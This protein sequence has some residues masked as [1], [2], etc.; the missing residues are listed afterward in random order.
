VGLVHG[1]LGGDNVFRYGGDNVFRC[2]N[3]YKV[4][5]WQ[6]PCRGPQALNLLLFVSRAGLDPLKYVS[7]AVAAIWAFLGAQWFIECKTRWIPESE[8]YDQTIADTPGEMKRL[9]GR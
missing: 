2:D 3:G 6:R 9:L 8:S 4:I 5:D 1:D 7:P